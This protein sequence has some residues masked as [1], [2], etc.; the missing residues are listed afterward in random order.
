MSALLVIVALAAF[1]AIGL[2][3][4]LLRANERPALA[5]NW[6]AVVRAWFATLHRQRAVG[7]GLVAGGALVLI[8]VLALRP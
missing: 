1:V 3:V 4:A 7:A 5:G 2:G 8:L 6:Q